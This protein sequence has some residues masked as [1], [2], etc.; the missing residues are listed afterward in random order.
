MDFKQASTQTDLL[1]HLHKQHSS[2]EAHALAV[3]H[4][5]VI[6]LVGGQHVEKSLTGAAHAPTKAGQ[7]DI[8]GRDEAFV[9]VVLDEQTVGGES[10]TCRE[11]EASQHNR[12]TVYRVILATNNLAFPKYQLIAM[13]YFSEFFIFHCANFDT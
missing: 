8:A 13:S 11:M 4:A 10:T 3:A 1:L 12:D 2:N 7:V 5:G 9:H 6:A